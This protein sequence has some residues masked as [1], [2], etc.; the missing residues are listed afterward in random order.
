MRATINGAGRS[1]RVAWAGALLLASVAPAAAQQAEPSQQQPATPEEAEF[2]R[3]AGA[4]KE[5]QEAGDPAGAAALIGRLVT[6]GETVVGLKDPDFLDML[7]AQGEYLAGFERREENLLVTERLLAGRTAAQ[8]PDHPKTIEAM[9]YRAAALLARGDYAAGEPLLTDAAARG[10]RVLGAEHQTTLLALNNLAVLRMEQGR[11]DE[12]EPLFQRALMA[13]ERVLGADHDET[14]D[15]LGA[16]ATMYRNQER[17]D[18]AEPLMRRVLATRERTQGPDAL[19]TVMAR[20]NL[21]WLLNVRG[22]FEEAQALFARA[23][24]AAAT[25]GADHLY[26]TD[27]MDGRAF[28]LIMNGKAAEAE[29]LAARVL[30]NR[31]RLQGPSHPSTIRSLSQLANVYLFTNRPA[32]AEPLL[33]RAKADSERRLGAEHPDTLQAM[34]NIVFARLSEPARAASA[35]DVARQMVVG[36]RTRRSGSA[37]GDLF[38]QA[39]AGRQVGGRIGGRRFVMLADALFAAVQAKGGPVAPEQLGEVLLSLQDASSGEASASIGRMAVRRYLE[40][41]GGDLAGLVRERE[42][43]TERW[44]SLSD[45][46][47]QSFNLEGAET[48]RERSRLRAERAGAEARMKAIDERLRK[49]FPDYFQLVRPQ[50]LQGPEVQNMLGADEAVLI[51][52]PGPFGTHVIAFSEDYAQWARA[53]LDDGDMRSAVG[54]LRYDAGAAVDASPQ[55]LAEWQKDRPAGDRM[56]FDRMTAFGLYRAMFEPVEA[57]LKGKKRV[58]VVAGGSLAALPFSMLVTERPEGADDDPASLRTTKWLAD[59]HALVHV[60]SLYSLAFLRGPAGKAATGGFVGFGDPALTGQATS[61]GARR[62]ASVPAVHEVITADRTP[63]GGAVANVSA[64]RQMEQLPGTARE[65]KAMADIFGAG[66]SRVFTRTTATE[67]QVRRADL[68]QARA[69]AFATHGLTPGDPVGEASASELFE[70]AEPGLVLTP[71]GQATPED[72]GFLSASEV[73][74]LRLN[75]DWVILSACNT[76]TGDAATAGLSQLARAF[77]YAGAR[78]LLASHWP[79][80]DEVAAKLTVRTLALEQAGAPRAEAFQQAMREIRSDPAHAEW[81]HPFYWS[82]FVLIGDGGK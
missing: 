82:P 81:A 70:L 25:L 56:S 8:G 6:L 52:V 26:V 66:S 11:T 23:E 79:V 38:G 64:L 50:A 61:R 33:L 80:D 9:L 74:T 40:G 24:Q 60:P 15:T 19:F 14:M 16:L 39:Q 73:S 29:A 27:A 35:L 55:Q 22:G 76:A 68:S 28:A 45:D 71:P 59:R 13:R 75:A 42:G 72:D 36:E 77:F 18:E 2:I 51:A 69:I 46:I 65:L 62:G 7:E 3:V 48:E 57:V 10:E 49:D 34:E 37:S 67:A 41:R 17:Y 63:W 44:L 47:A 30:A 5:R 43:L 20:V 58:Y 21:G 31:E 53:V 54:R 12:A 32:L 4:V 1:V 78:I